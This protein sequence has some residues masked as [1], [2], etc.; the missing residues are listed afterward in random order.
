MRRPRLVYTSLFLVSFAGCAAERPDVE[1]GTNDSNLADDP[2]VDVGAQSVDDTTADAGVSPARCTPGAGRE[3]KQTYY[4][5]DGR[6]HCPVSTQYCRADGLGWLACGQPPEP[7][8][9]ADP[10][11]P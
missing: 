4:D 8:A 3:C 1:R 9:S 7:P 6:K 2:P 5:A 10:D 11:A